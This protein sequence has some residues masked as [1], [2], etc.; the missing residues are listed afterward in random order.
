CA[1]RV[2]AAAAADPHAGLAERAAPG[3]ALARSAPQPAHP[4]AGRA[5]AAP[6]LARPAAPLAPRG[7]RPAA[8]LVRPARPRRGRRRADHLRV[9]RLAGAPPRRLAGAPRRD[10][11]LAAREGGAA[12]AARGARV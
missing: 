12:P 10:R 8:G 5:V 11:L 3:R 4:P 6:A 7:P 1:V 9:Q 2:R